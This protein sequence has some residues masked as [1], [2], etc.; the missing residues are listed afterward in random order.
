MMTTRET[1]ET[2][3]ITNERRAT[4]LTNTDQAGDRPEQHH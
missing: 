4:Q 3:N 2:V 1:I